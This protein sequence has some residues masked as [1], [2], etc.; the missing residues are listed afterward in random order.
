MPYGAKPIPFGHP[1]Q[2]VGG[3]QPYY[4]SIASQIPQSTEE[5]VSQEKIDTKPKKPTGLS[6]TIPEPMKLGKSLGS[7][8]SPSFCPVMPLIH[9]PTIS[10]PN[11]NLFAPSPTS[12]PFG[13]FPHDYFSHNTL[14][15]NPE[16]SSFNENFVKV[17]QKSHDH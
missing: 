12:A 2:F 15:S 14:Q 7:P 1:Y 4:F 13:I 3:Y 6:I 16:K 10:T 9:S 17:N 8:T 11:P 5:Q